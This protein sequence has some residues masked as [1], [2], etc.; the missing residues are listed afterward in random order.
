MKMRATFD[1]EYEAEATAANQEYTL[2]RALTRAEAA[3]KDS[4][5]GMGIKKNSTTIKAIS[6]IK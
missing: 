3:L 1:V 6:E 4:I 2:R 5:E